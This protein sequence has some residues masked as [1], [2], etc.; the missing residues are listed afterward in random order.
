MNKWLRTVL[1]HDIFYQ[2][3]QTFLIIFI[4]GNGGVT[5]LPRRVENCFE[6]FPEITDLKIE[7]CSVSYS[8]TSLIVQKYC[9]YLDMKQFHLNKNNLKLLDVLKLVFCFLFSILKFSVHGIISIAWILTLLG[10]WHWRISFCFYLEILSFE[11]Q[12]FTKFGWWKCL[13][14]SLLSICS[15]VCCVVV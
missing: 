10:S 4:F 15:Y 1:Y 12:S 3:S 11:D 13:K 2:A 8:D 6:Y 9:K 5:D 7:K 14:N